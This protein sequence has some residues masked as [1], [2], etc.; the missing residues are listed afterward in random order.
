M[1]NL[2][3]SL[4][5]KLNSLVVKFHGLGDKLSWF[6]WKLYC[7]SDKLQGSDDKLQEL[8]GWTLIKPGDIHSI[9]GIFGRYVLNK[10]FSERVLM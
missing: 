9:F 5:H 7:F 1:I 2:L 3:Y 6:E 4:D 10:M 8:G